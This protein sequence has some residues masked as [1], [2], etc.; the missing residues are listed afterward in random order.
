MATFS[1]TIPTEDL[2]DTVAA[3]SQGWTEDSGLTKQQYA[4]AQIK[5]Y[6]KSTVKHYRESKQVVSEPDIDIT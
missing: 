6:L 5:N 3:F 2:P 4:K 1:I